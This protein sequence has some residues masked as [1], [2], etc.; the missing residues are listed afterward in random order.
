VHGTTTAPYLD[1][2]ASGYSTDVGGHLGG[3][4]LV[5]AELDCTPG[6]EVAMPSRNSDRVVVLDIEGGTLKPAFAVP[7][8]GN[9]QNLAVADLDGDGDQDIFVAHLQ[10]TFSVLPN[11][12]NGNFDPP[13]VYPAGWVSGNNPVPPSN[14]PDKR[15]AVGPGY[16]PGQPNGLA[17]ALGFGTRVAVKCVD[18]DG[19][20]PIAKEPH[21]KTDTHDNF[22]D[23]GFELPPS[24]FGIGGAPPTVAGLALEGGELFA[25]RHGQHSDYGRLWYLVP[26]KC[27]FTN[28]SVKVQI[29]ELGSGGTIRDMA[30]RQLEKRIQDDLHLSRVGDLSLRGTIWSDKERER[31]H[32]GIT[33]VSAIGDREIAD[34][35]STKEFRRGE[36]A[37][38]L[39]TEL[40]DLEELSRR[41][42]LE[43]WSRVA[44]SGFLE[45]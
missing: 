14:S 24:Q 28:E 27:A 40:Y 33:F 20:F 12:C 19:N 43:T 39:R 10:P 26:A 45:E 2:A 7:S 32:L 44:V 38:L 37:P 5:V 42:E 13:Q 29:A 15:I 34:S 11:E 22:L 30:E 9:A 21:G 35:L 41:P 4:Q 36:R 16:C 25:L 3:L 1:G 8:G 17:V 6:L 31:K 23:Y 18:E